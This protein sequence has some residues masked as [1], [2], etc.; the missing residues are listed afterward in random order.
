LVHERLTGLQSAESSAYASQIVQLGSKVQKLED[1][2][3]KLLRDVSAEQQSPHNRAIAHTN[4]ELRA[5]L[6]TAVTMLRQCQQVF[7]SDHCQAA[8][9]LAGQA[10]QVP[11]IDSFAASCVPLGVADQREF[12]PK[13]DFASPSCDRR[14]DD[15]AGWYRAQQTQQGGSTSPK[16]GMPTSSFSFPQHPS[17]QVCTPNWLSCLLN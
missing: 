5:K 7:C 2:N 10:S 11:D 16:A 13:T 4:A 15:G 6:T 8:S 12:T 9:V 1:E 17:A 3:A 14:A